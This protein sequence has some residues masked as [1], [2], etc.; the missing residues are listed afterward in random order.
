MDIKL[1]PK[2]TFAV[3]KKKIKILTGRKVIEKSRSLA[4]PKIL[5]K[6]DIIIGQV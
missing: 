5:Y 2:L 3:Q 1:K 4:K 6:V